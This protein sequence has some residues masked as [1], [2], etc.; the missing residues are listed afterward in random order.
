MIVPAARAALSKPM[1]D[2]TS[3]IS[4]PAQL[5]L[6]A[7]SRPSLK[8]LPAPRQAAAALNS[9]GMA[10]MMAIFM[11]LH[12]RADDTVLTTTFQGII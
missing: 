1:P 6:R 3:R 12:S 8:L 2:S 5:D 4:C 11:T 7:L 9:S 10:V